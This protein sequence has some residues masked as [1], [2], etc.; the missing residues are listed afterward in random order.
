MFA[1]LATWRA[2]RQELWRGTSCAEAF[3]RYSKHLTDTIV[4]MLLV[5]AVAVSLTLCQAVQRTQT[6]Q[7]RFELFDR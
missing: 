6:S 3:Q 1:W 7:N 4:G 5:S 2:W